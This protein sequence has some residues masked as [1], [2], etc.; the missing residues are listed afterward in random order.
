MSICGGRPGQTARR[1]RG[2]PC[3]PTGGDRA[4][5]SKISLYPSIIQRDHFACAAEENFFSLDAGSCRRRG[6]ARSP[7]E[8]REVV[9]LNVGCIDGID[10]SKLRCRRSTG[11]KGHANRPQ[12]NCGVFV[13]FKL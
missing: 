1:M 13:L 7:A 9:A 8:G 4:I 11:G 12:A 6:R 3:A 2:R 5:C 10:R